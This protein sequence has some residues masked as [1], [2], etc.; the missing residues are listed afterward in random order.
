MGNGEN[1]I[2]SDVTIQYITLVEDSNKGGGIFINGTYAGVD[3]IGKYSYGTFENIR[4]TEVKAT[5][6]CVG[7][8]IYLLTN[9][10]DNLDSTKQTFKSLNLIDSFG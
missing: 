2:L 1:L 4:F 8:R 5:S 10:N 7:S 6:K 3:E 9:N